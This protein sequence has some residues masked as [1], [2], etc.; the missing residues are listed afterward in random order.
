VIAAIFMVREGQGVRAW[1]A[2]LG[3]LAFPVLLVVTLISVYVFVVAA[4]VARAQMSAT[5]VGGGGTVQ[6]G[7]GLPTALPAVEAK[8]GALPAHGALLVTKG[9]LA[10]TDFDSDSSA[11]STLTSRV[12]GM[13]LDQFMLLDEK[14]QGL[15]ADAAA[16]ALPPGTVAHRV[17]DVVF[18]YHG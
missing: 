17:G 5:V 3:A 18:T 8:T 11:S 2:A 10:P 7:R 14:R 1:R 16:R 12:A 9:G 6:Q 13:S 4:A 15:A